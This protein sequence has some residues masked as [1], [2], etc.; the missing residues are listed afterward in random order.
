MAHERETKNL[1]RDYLRRS[2]GFQGTLPSRGASR[3]ADGVANDPQR[4][5]VGNDGDVD[6]VG[7][8][9]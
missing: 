1:C 5:R 3:S 2:R 4:T 7:S 9:R 8:G 6:V